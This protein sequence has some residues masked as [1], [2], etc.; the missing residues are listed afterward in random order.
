MDMQEIMRYIEVGSGYVEVDR[1]YPEKYKGLCRRIYIRKNEIQIDF[2][3]EQDIEINEGETTF[4]FVY[5]SSEDVIKSAEAFLKKPVSEWT[6]YNSTW[7]EWHFPQ[8]DKDCY[9]KLWK[10]LQS[11]V[12]DFPHGFNYFYI[13]NYMARG[14]F[15]GIINPE[16]DFEWTV[17]L[18]LQIEKSENNFTEY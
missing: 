2:C 7:N 4:Y 13:N 1:S 12:L 18:I 14:V 17:D 5:R 6:N 8:A 16:A 10:D 11:H 15:L 3:T 9:V